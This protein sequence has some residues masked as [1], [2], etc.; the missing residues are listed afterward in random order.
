MFIFAEPRRAK[1]S[2]VFACLGELLDGGFASF[3]LVTA[4][5][6]SDI[7]FSVD[8]QRVEQMCGIYPINAGLFSKI[9]LLSQHRA[10]GSRFLQESQHLAMLLSMCPL[11]HKEWTLDLLAKGGFV[12]PR[13]VR[14]KEGSCV[15]ARIWP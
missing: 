2:N 5:L 12:L 1:R 15:E 9:I 10:R 6:D 14:A 3:T 4:L 7:G 8:L 13:I 11:I